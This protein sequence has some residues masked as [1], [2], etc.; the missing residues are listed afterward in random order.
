MCNIETERRS[1]FHKM[2]MK[3]IEMVTTYI[4]DPINSAFK[5][6]KYL[7]ILIDYYIMDQMLATH[8][9]FRLLLI[10]GYH[11]YELQYLRYI[12]ANTC[13]ISMRR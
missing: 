1:A 6:A 13:Y 12:M 9:T 5:Y 4:L 11:G 7:C 3:N 10:I 8:W 2:L